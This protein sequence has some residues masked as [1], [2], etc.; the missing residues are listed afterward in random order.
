MDCQKDMNWIVADLCTR[1]SVQLTNKV[2]PAQSGTGF[3]SF[4]HSVALSNQ[5]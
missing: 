3:S 1:W 5:S 2:S 4:S